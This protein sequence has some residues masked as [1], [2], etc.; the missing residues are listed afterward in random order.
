MGTFEED[1]PRLAKSG[2][3]RTPEAGNM[4]AELS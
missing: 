1:M 4:R 2:S 3:N